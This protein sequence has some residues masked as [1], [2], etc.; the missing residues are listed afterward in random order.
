MRQSNFGME[1]A[2]NEFFAGRPHFFHQKIDYYDKSE[3]FVE[4]MKIH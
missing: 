2:E 4:L 3:A 1:K